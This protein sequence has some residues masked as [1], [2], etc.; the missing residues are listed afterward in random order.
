MLDHDF[1]HL[2]FGRRIQMSGHSDFGIFSNVGASSIL[3]GVSADT[4]SVACPAHLGNLDMMSMTFAAV[5]CDAEDHCSVNTAYD[6][7]SSFTMSP[8]NATL[9][10]YF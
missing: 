7:E 6:P 8:R 3:T 2:C 4:A 5:I 1:G 10:L 9:P